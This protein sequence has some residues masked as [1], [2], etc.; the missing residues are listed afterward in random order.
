[1]ILA[2]AGGSGSG[3][4]TVAKQ[5]KDRY[6]KNAQKKVVII[7]MDDYYKNKHTEAFA[8]YD[9]PDAFHVDA[10]YDDLQHFLHSGSI[11]RR[12]Y[13]YVSKQSH[14]LPTKTQVDIVIVEGLYSFYER[15]IR[16][17]CTRTVYLDVEEELRIQRRLRRDVKERGIS[18]QSNMQMLEDFVIEMH[19][20]YVSQQKKMADELYSD[21]ND[22]LS[23]VV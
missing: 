19:T 1:M 4:T 18:V 8:N 17:L 20:K 14:Y 10:L 2:I 7:S 21:S 15:K 12:R 16:D 13:D 6:Q 9:H 3:K 22:V 23:F 11:V 5:L